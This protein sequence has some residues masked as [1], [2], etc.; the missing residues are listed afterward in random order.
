[1]LLSVLDLTG[2]SRI[3]RRAVLNM[4]MTFGYHEGDELVLPISQNDSAPS[5]QLI[6]LVLITTTIIIF[7]NLKITPF[8]RHFLWY[9]QYK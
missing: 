4:V 1:M 3:Q 7:Q 2:K 6:M 9:A 8:L 5:A